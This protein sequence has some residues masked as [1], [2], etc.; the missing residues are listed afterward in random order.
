[1]KEREKGCAEGIAE[2]VQKELK[3]DKLSLLST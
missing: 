3:S 2:G 1:M